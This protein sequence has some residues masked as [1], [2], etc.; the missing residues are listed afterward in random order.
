MVLEAGLALVALA[1]AL[2]L[3]PWRLL[4][5][6]PAI[7]TPLLGTLVVL[8]WLWALPALHRAPLQLRWSGAVLVLLMLGWPLAV[9]VLLL[10][11][12]LAWAVSPLAPQAALAVAVWHG[13]VPATFALLLGAALRRWLPPHP[14]VYVLGR[15]FL[16]AVLCLFAAGL[17][18]QAV[19]APLPGVSTELGRV[20]QWLMAWG[21][22]F[23]TGML[24][25][26]F[27]AFKPQWLLTWS[28]QRYLPR[29]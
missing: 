14:F 18:G 20:A 17:L 26:I 13:I 2:W 23:V 27:V 19:G 25:A 9:P 10:V 6:H 7:A 11:G 1:I 12:V 24:T 22:A 29:P 21:D 4:A 16:G 5:A 8:P 15:G 28:D 3:R